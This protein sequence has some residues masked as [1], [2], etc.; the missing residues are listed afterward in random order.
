MERVTILLQLIT[1]AISI[2]FAIVCGTLQVVKYIKLKK[3][4]RL[5]G[6]ADSTLTQIWSIVNKLPEYISVAEEKYKAFK[7]MGS[8]N[9]GEMKFSDVLSQI[10]IDCLNNN[11]D[12]DLD[13]WTKQ[14]ND[15]VDFSKKVNNKEV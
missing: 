13:F 15:L 10:K 1:V 8:S 14:I 4:K 11:I 6:L 12:F 7:R 3:S 2:V 9:T 5:D